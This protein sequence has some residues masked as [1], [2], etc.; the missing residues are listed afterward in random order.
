MPPVRVYDEFIGVIQAAWRQC[1]ARN[2]NSRR[3]IFEG[4]RAID[5]VLLAKANRKL[6]DALGVDSDDL[7]AAVR[8]M[9]LPKLWQ[10]VY[11]V[12]IVRW[13]E[14]YLKIG[15]YLDLRDANKP[16]N[17]AARGLVIGDE[18]LSDRAVTAAVRREVVQRNVHGLL[19]A[20]HI[21]PEGLVFPTDGRV[22]F[23]KLCAIFGDAEHMDAI[24]LSQFVHRGN[25]KAI[26][27]MSGETLADLGLDYTHRS[28]TTTLKNEV[29]IVTG[30]T[31][32]Q[33][34]DE[35]RRVYKDHLP[36]LF[37]RGVGQYLAEMRAKVIAMP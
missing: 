31:D 29:R 5:N 8:F 11:R 2:R 18:L 9:Y 10:D 7:L 35:L 23:K 33:L 24:N 34:I 15:I 36:E 20:H 27:A 13:N 21:I 16:L 19:E 25:A 3:G 17:T 12:W 30:M 22:P 32:V 37:N 28:V 14:S 26:A 4:R 1:N 6:I